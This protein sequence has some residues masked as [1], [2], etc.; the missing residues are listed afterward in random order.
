MVHAD[1]GFVNRNDTDQPEIRN[2]SKNS[3]KGHLFALLALEDGPAAT[4]ING[5]QGKA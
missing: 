1:S 2:R 3:Q 4:K 5:K